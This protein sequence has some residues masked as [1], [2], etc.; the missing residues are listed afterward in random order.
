[1]INIRIVPTLKSTHCYLVFASGVKIG[2]K[3]GG[4]VGPLSLLMA[5]HEMYFVTSEIGWSPHGGFDIIRIIRPVWVS[6]I[7]IHYLAGN[8]VIS[9]QERRLLLR[10]HNRMNPL[11]DDNHLLLRA[12][13]KG[14]EIQTYRS[15]DP[16]ARLHGTQATSGFV[17][18]F[19]DGSPRHILSVDADGLPDLTDDARTALR[20][21]LRT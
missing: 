5:P 1:M 16:L 11:P 20:A 8:H 12:I 17:L 4:E 14:C 2:A 7:M 21:Y 10:Q 9:E 6:Q 15:D 13:L 3:H 18:R 19:P